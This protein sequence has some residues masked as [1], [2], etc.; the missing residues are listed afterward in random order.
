M[1]EAADAIE[2][3]ATK[4]ATLQDSCKWIPVSERPPKKDVPVFVYLFG[5]GPYIAWINRDGE[6]ETE[7]FTVD[8]DYLPKTW[9]PLPEPPKEVDI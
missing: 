9:F 2:E 3:L 6:W 4:L 1:T 7:D 8:H 5:S